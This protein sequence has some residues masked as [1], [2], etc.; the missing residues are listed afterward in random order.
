MHR[1]SD[2]VFDEILIKFW[3]TFDPFLINFASKLASKSHIE[4][5]FEFKLF[6]M[7]FL[8]PKSLI[9]Y[10]RVIENALFANARNSTKKLWKC[11]QN[12]LQNQSK[13]IQNRLW[14]GL[15]F[16][17][18]FLHRKWPKMTPKWDLFFLTIFTFWCFRWE[19]DPFCLSLF[20]F[21]WFWWQ[22]APNFTH[23]PGNLWSN[24][25]NYWI[26]FENINIFTLF[27]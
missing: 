16:R 2:H 10:G 5:D 17:T 14:N 1:F 20:T 3:S 8:H 26:V 21:W 9:S 18:H 13:S 25:R 11:Y 4:N 27:W 23:W 19:L 22:V 12:E 24:H 15:A 7:P 6:S